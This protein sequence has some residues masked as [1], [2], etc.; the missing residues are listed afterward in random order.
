LAS[1]SCQAAY[2]ALQFVPC[3]K[4]LCFSTIRLLNGRI[5]GFIRR[6]RGFELN[7]V[8][9]HRVHDLDDGE[10]FRRYSPPSTLRISLNLK[11]IRSFS[12]CLRS[13]ISD[14]VLEVRQLVVKELLLKHQLLLFLLLC[15]PQSE[16]DKTSECNSCK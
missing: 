12:L 9:V 8:G 11:V 15:S 5:Y 4:S 16:P 14:L 7:R 1:I 10:P 2:L 3:L 6:H 13:T